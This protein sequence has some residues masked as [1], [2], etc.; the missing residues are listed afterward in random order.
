MTPVWLV[1]AGA[2]G[3]SFEPFLAEMRQH[4]VVG[5]VIQPGP[6]LNG[7]T[8]VIG[9]S[10][11]AEGDCVVFSGTH[12][13]MRFIQAHHPS[14]VPGGWCTAENFDCAAYYPAF[15]RHLLNHVHAIRTTDDA[16]A[17]ADHLFAEFARDGQVFLR[18]CGVQKT[19]TGRCVDRDGFTLALESAQYAG[20]RVLVSSPQ[21]IA[22][23][24]RVVVSRGRFV[25]GSRYFADGRL[26]P[27]PDCPRRVAE[28]VTAV[29]AEV[30]YR[31]D[32]IFMM[33][34]CESAGRLS[35]LELNSF[36]CSGPYRCDPAAVVREVKDLAVETWRRAGAAAGGPT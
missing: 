17:E 31:P 20:G 23:E 13:V 24:W 12:P 6:F 30:P 32:P 3:R 35:L 2:F 22:V 19:F 36:S 21:P 11:I 33:D 7:L 5:E 1:E 14:W 34:V 10:R 27:S 18:P 4:G 29:L 28:Y 9:G 16:L 25:A 8:P 15:G 26:D